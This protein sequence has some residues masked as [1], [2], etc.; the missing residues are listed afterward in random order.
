M[1]PN[2]D[3]PTDLIDLLSQELG[4]A[5]LYANDD[6]FASKDNLILP[7]EA[8]WKEDAYTDRGKWMDG[9]ES[10]R[11]R[12][13]G[14]DYCF[15]K[16]ALPGLIRKV[17]VDTAFFTGNYPD[18]CSLEGCVLGANATPEALEKADWFT[19]LEDSKLAGGSKNTFDL[20]YAGKVTHLRF[21]IF[22]DGGV[23]RLRAFGEVLPK[24]NRW[25]SL[26][27]ID[28]ASIT[29]GAKT[30]SQS[31][32]YFGLASNLLKPNR[33]VNM[34]DGW[35]T[36]RSRGAGHLDWCILEL[37]ANG[38]IEYVQIDTN[39]FKG[40]YPDRCSL[41]VATTLK[42]KE[43]EWTMILDEVKLQAHT[44]HEFEKELH[45]IDNI[46][47]VRF[48]IFPDGGIS[49]LRLFGKVSSQGWEEARLRDLKFVNQEGAK[50][51]F[52]SACGSKK[53]VEGMVSAQQGDG[54]SSLESIQKKAKEVFQSLED[55]DWLEAFRSHPKIGGE[56]AEDKVS[57]NS[58]QWSSKEQVGVEHAEEKTL[59]RLAELNQAYFEKHDFIFIVFASGKSAGEMLAILEERLNNETKTEI[60]NASIAQEKITHTR[61]E[62]WIKGQ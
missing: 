13:E 53:W 8:V 30:L 6:F 50:A 35:E 57:Q 42:G 39:H 18:S 15:I 31:D 16:L 36:K 32:M 54:F 41:E 29:H 25:K 11:K 4:G 58:S 51:Y 23:A 1:N 48:K 38:K 43:T 61:L 20:S 37:A 28:L 2:E 10:R 34:G 21:N 26:G 60:K 59:S 22:P 19:L 40:N 62:K 7:A 45:E 17:I 24:L 5:V 9:W 55:K 33:G 52:S 12:I 46:R 44:L 49:R 56:K 27:Q 3:I 14:H 47:F